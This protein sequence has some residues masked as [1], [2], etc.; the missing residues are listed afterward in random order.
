MIMED[1]VRRTRRLIRRALASLQ[2]WWSRRVGRLRRA[3]KLPRVFKIVR[4]NELCSETVRD[5]AT[6]VALRTELELLRLHGEDNSFEVLAALRSPD[7]FDADPGAVELREI[8]EDAVNPVN[9]ETMLAIDCDFPDVVRELDEEEILAKEKAFRQ[10]VAQ[11]LISANSESYGRIVDLYVT[12]AESARVR[13]TDVDDASDGVLESETSMT[14]KDELN[15]NEEGNTAEAGQSEDSVED[16]LTSMEGEL[17]NLT[18]MVAGEDEQSVLVA[19]PATS[20]QTGSEMSADGQEENGTSASLDESDI[21][22]ALEEAQALA[23]IS[24][25]PKAEDAAESISDE[26]GDTTSPEA[27]DEAVDEVEEVAA[28]AL[29]EQVEEQESVVDDALSAAS[30]ELVESVAEEAE[31]VEEVVKA[32]AVEELLPPEDEVDAVLQ[33]MSEAAVGEGSVSGEPADEVESEVAGIQSELQEIE[34]VEESQGVSEPAAEV[35]ALAEVVSEQGSPEIDETPTEQFVMATHAEESD[36]APVEDESSRVEASVEQ[37]EMQTPSDAMEYREREPSPI[38]R[39]AGTSR[40]AR[41]SRVDVPRRRGRRATV[42]GPAGEI[43]TAIENLAAFLEDEISPLWEEAQDTLEEINAQRDQIAAIKQQLAEE[44]REVEAMREE[45]EAAYREARSLQM[46]MQ[47]LRDEAM[48]SRQR[49]DVAAQD[50]QTAADRAI[51]AAR[52][53]ELAAKLRRD[54]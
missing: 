20:E 5:R 47:N 45:T 12:S 11:C 37:E 19:K 28:E 40:S 43:G 22:A 13:T 38:A 44:R 21:E 26:I 4:G 16:A 46:Q 52:E 14:D 2:T 27:L 1:T 54:K 25:Q 23:E 7:D 53:L 36:S 10:R 6:L 24:D 35:E 3:G 39:D 34:A 15:I 42:R 9:E 29:G 41:R 49:A 33:E 31:D 18:E 17:H 51:A 32:D 30:S 8:L 48:R 50:A